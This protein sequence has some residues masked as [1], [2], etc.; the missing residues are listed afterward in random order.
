M[1]DL[2]QC[3]TIILQII[4]LV[5]INAFGFIYDSEYVLASISIDL[6]VLGYNINVFNNIKKE[7][8]ST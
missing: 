2:D 4:A 7:K 3:K 6:L 5:A 8:S 1:V